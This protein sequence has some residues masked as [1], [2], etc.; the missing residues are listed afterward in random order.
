VLRCVR[1]HVDRVVTV[2][3]RPDW[4]LSLGSSSGVQSRRCFRIASRRVSSSRIYRPCPVPVSVD[5]NGGAFPAGPGCGH[6]GSPTTA[7]QGSSVLMAGID[8]LVYGMRACDERLESGESRK[9]L[10]R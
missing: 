4:V 1:P 3:P 2:E 6:L 5:R 7:L 9:G 8:H 10:V